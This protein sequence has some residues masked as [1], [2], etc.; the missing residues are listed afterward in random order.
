MANLFL[1]AGPDAPN[2]EELMDL[3]EGM[4]IVGTGRPNEECAGERSSWYSW[5]CALFTAASLT[6]AVDRFDNLLGD[7]QAGQI[8]SG[9]R[10]I[11][12]SGRAQARQ[13]PQRRSCRCTQS[14]VFKLLF[15]PPSTCNIKD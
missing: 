6:R 8:S 3:P 15:F 14:H 4:S 7:S 10:L 1:L 5:R 12:C 13:Q 11:L 2:I 9:P